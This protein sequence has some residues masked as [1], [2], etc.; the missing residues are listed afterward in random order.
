MGSDPELEQGIVDDGET[1]CTCVGFQGKSK[2]ENGH[3][4]PDG[5]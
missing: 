1:L 5:E 2:K 4:D 3:D